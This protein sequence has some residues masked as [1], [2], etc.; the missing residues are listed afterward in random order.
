[1]NAREIRKVLEKVVIEA[2]ND[3]HEAQNRRDPNA[4]DKA[5]ESC[6]A[7]EIFEK[8]Y[9]SDALEALADKHFT[10]D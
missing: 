4:R 8:L 9:G 3:F 5:I 10:E 2:H 6:K 7:M 1:M